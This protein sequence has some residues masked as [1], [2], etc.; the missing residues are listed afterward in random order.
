ML[1]FKRQGKEKFLKIVRD[2]VCRPG[3]PTTLL[4]FAATGRGREWENFY[5]RTKEE[6]EK[7]PNLT[8]VSL[9]E[10]E[11]RLVFDLFLKENLIVEYQKWLHKEEEEVGE[12]KKGEEDEEEEDSEYF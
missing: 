9:T 10:E 2:N 1:F 11:K 3:E 12:G 4:S 7:D 6:G 5:R 8:F